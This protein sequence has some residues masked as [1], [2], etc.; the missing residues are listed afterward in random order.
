MVKDLKNMESNNLN[1]NSEKIESASIVE[2]Y[3]F[4][5]SG[6]FFWRNGENIVKQENRG[7]LFSGLFA[8]L[9]SYTKETLG[10]T[11]SHLIINDLKIRIFSFV[12]NYIIAIVTPK[13]IK[14]DQRMIEDL[15]EKINKIVKTHI[16]NQDE[17]LQRTIK[18]LDKLLTK[19]IDWMQVYIKQSKF[20]ITKFLE[21]IHVLDSHNVAIFLYTWDWNRVFKYTSNIEI[22]LQINDI[23]ETIIK[24]ED[25]EKIDK[26][27]MI[28]LDTVLF[29]SVKEMIL[30]LAKPLDFNKNGFPASDKSIMDITNA[31]ANLIPIVDEIILLAKT[32]QIETGE[33]N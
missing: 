29:I 27:V 18:E 17:M 8:S 14:L 7:I 1:P 6:E 24:L 3:L 31:A 16:K 19:L 20:A 10:E 26:L 23:I 21:N 13:Y 4:N 32:Q 15:E 9:F 30:I 5:K 11:L 22:D 25:L 33:N 12:D 2:V 28:I